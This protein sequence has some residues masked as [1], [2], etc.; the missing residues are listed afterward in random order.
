M[1]RGATP[2]RADELRGEREDEHTR[3]LAAAVGDRL[4]YELALHAIELAAELER[5]A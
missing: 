1:V 3:L 4:P 5:S 2:T